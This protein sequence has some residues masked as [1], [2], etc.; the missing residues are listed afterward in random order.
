MMH[1]H[2]SSLLQVFVSKKL[3]TALSERLM[4]PL[5]RRIIERIFLMGETSFFWFLSPVNSRHPAKL[6]KEVSSG[7]KSEKY[8]NLGKP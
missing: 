5:T 6:E 7:I 4:K 8:C 1:L 2:F 3:V